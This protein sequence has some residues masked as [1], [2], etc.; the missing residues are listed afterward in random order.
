MEDPAPPGPQPLLLRPHPQLTAPRSLALLE[1][2]SPAGPLGT[3]ADFL[4]CPPT[5]TMALAKRPLP[6]AGPGA[7]RA[8]PASSGARLG[9]GSDHAAR[10]GLVGR[11]TAAPHVESY[12][13][14]PRPPAR[15]EKAVEA[16]RV[17]RG[18][19]G[20]QMVR[21]GRCWG[22]GL[23]GLWEAVLLC[24]KWGAL[25]YYLEVLG[26]VASFS[27]LSSFSFVLS[28]PPSLPSVCLRL[29]SRE[30]KSPS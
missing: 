14:L 10:V 25:K 7:P 20:A 15:G 21:M 13:P 1:Q 12:P 30:E 23:S 4:L 8:P 27:L 16:R 26:K 6:L 9:P 11:D 2:T 3:E 29:C 18:P 22:R 24:R 19:L 17:E 5:H 28:L